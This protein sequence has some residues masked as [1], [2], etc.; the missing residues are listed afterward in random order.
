MFILTEQRGNGE[1]RAKG[2]KGTS[3]E[4]V[5]QVGGGGVFQQQQERWK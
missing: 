2:R 3:G 4:R 5:P 1:V